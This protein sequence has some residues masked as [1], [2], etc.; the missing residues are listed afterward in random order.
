[1]PLYNYMCPKCGSRRDAFR[2]ITDRHQGPACC[3]TPMEQK[4]TGQYAI[5]GN[6]DFVTDDITGDPIRIESRKQHDQVC[7]KNGVSPMYGKGWS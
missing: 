1:M 3:N 7:E 6:V 4:I 2:K 5:H